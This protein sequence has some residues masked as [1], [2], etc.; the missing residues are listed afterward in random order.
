MTT[1]DENYNYDEILQER[2]DADI[3]TAKT[4]ASTDSSANK[5]TV[6]ASSAQKADSKK[7]SRLLLDER[8]SIDAT[9]KRER[10]Q[11]DD[12]IQ[13]SSDLLREE[14][15]AHFETKAALLTR[16]DFLAIV[17]HDLRNPIGTVLSC[18]DMLL[19]D[20]LSDNKKEVE[21][22]ISLIKRNAEVSLR[23]IGDLLDM[24]RVAEGRLELQLA[25]FDLVDLVKKSVEN[26]V[27]LAA[28]K[29][30]IIR[31]QSSHSRIIFKCD[32]DRIAQVLSNLIGNALKFTHEAGS[33][34]VEANQTEELVS[35]TVADTGT[36]I[37]IDQQGQI[38]NRFTQLNRKDRRGLGLGLYISKMLVDAHGGHISVKSV[39]G[40]GSIFSIL[41]PKK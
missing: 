27:T 31:A 6:L 8:A 36:G 16:D 35:I 34:I 29:S 15:N 37:P 33:V 32:G 28:A 9:M 5:G 4:R 39:E 18:A 7:L 17:S 2:K 14:V 41:I 1:S 25:N 40:R 21:Q 11:F 13:K 24:E 38:F 12:V 3:E 10:L 22:W 20:G 19:D 23:L 26:V 30:I